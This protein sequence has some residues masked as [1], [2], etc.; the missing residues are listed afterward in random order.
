M[1]ELPEVET[2]RK[3]LIQ[4]ENGFPSLLSQ[5]IQRGEVFW[6]K[7]IAQP[8]ALEFQRKVVGQC[9]S[10]IERRGKFLILQLTEEYLL[11]HLRMS[12]DLLLQIISEPYPT[13]A[14][15]ALVFEQGFRLVFDD[16]RKF[17]RTWLV[18]DTT[19]VL[20]ALGPEPLDENFS[21]EAFFQRLQR[22]RRQIKPLLLDQSFLAGLGNIYTDESLHLAGI[23]P[24]T[25][26]DSLDFEEA[27]RLIESIRAILRKS[28]EYMGTTID[29]VY[30][31]GRFQNHFTVY[32]RAGKPCF[33]CGNP[34][35]RQTVMQRGTYFCHICQPLE[36]SHNRSGGK[37][38][39]H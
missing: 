25:P 14:R 4:G 5:C 13:H 1:P 27:Q 2:I 12:G 11:I 20:G 22:H 31:G 29:W 33:H 15:W 21:A 19:P 28:I 30:R 18:A 16:A 23:H 3:R 34:I 8:T 38:D 39:H 37:D 10:A 24:Q 7:T 17:G 9:I 26:S 36:A 32:Q 35:Q 6:E